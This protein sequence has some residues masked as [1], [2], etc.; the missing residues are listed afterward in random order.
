MNTQRKN[1]KAALIASA[2]LVLLAGSSSAQAQSTIRYTRVYESDSGYC[3]S[4]DTVVTVSTVRPRSYR[5][6]Y[7]E[8]TYRNSRVVVTYGEPTYTEPVYYENNNYVEYVRYP[9]RSHYN[10][11]H[12]SYDRSR[13]HRSSRHYSRY[14]GHRLERRLHRIGRTLH[15]IGHFAR[16]SHHRGHRSLGSVLR[17]GLHGRQHGRSS[18]RS[19]R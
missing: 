9:S 18:H 16:S 7:T 8:P 10:N 2:G 13:H 5:R 14:D 19:H 17:R 1:L 11:R 6:V 12:Y 3:Q 15:R 4:R